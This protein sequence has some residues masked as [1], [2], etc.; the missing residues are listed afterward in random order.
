MI[1]GNIFEIISIV[2]K[3]NESSAARGCFFSDIKDLNK[4]GLCIMNDPSTVTTVSN[5]V[6]CVFH[7]KNT[8]FLDVINN[9]LNRTD[10]MCEMFDESDPFIYSVKYD[11][12]AFKVQ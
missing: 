3:F 4:K 1:L 12:R 7:C 10:I 2:S 8:H 9:E 5:A 11:C 6:Q